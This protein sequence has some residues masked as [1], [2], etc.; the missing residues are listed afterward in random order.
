MKRAGINRMSVAIS[1]VAGTSDM[2]HKNP[3]NIVSG[4]GYGGLAFAKGIVFGITG[5]VTEPVKGGMK[6]GPKGAAVGLGKGFVGLFAK[7]IG[8]T[9]GLVGCT[10]QGA[11]STPGTIKRAVTGKPNGGAAA[12]GAAAANDVEE[13]KSDGGMEFDGGADGHVAN[14]DNEDE[15][16][17][18]AIGP[19]ALD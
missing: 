4:L 14:T 11:V 10:V 13:S 16:F 7:P 6:K 1:N 5:V 15:K 8:G 17:N 3:K 2:K 18:T 9:V 19:N 12:A